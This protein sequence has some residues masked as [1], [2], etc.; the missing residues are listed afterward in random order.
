[1]SSLLARRRRL[2]VACVVAVFGFASIA[3]AATATHG[4][5]APTRR[6]HARAATTAS[7]ASSVPD[8]VLLGD[9]NVESTRGGGNGTSEAFGWIASVSGTATDITVYLESTDGA[10]VGLYA[11][12]G[13]SRPGLRLDR[14][15][16]YSNNAGWVRISLA[17]GAKVVSGQRYWIAI[18]ARNRT[19][20]IVYLDGGNHGP[21]FDYGGSG[22]SNPYSI[23]GHYAADPVSAYVDGIADSGGATLPP[24]NTGRPT[25]SGT[26]QQ[27]GVLTGSP[28][29]WTN[30]PTSFAYQWRRCDPS[31]AN[32]SELGG[33]TSSSYTMQASDV[34]STLQLQVT[35]SNSGGSA[36][37]TSLPTAVVAGPTGTGGSQTLHCFHSPGACGFPDPAYGNVGVPAGTTLTPSGPITVS[38][39][40]AIISGLDI[41]TDSAPGIRIQADN[42]TVKNTRITLAGGGCGT[43]STCGSALIRIDGQNDTIS[44]VELATASGITSEFAIH[45]ASGDAVAIDHVYSHGPDSLL[46]DWANHATVS[47]SYSRI[48]LRIANDHLENVYCSGGQTLTLNHNTLEDQ[49]GQVASAVFCNTSLNGSLGAPCT[50]HLTLTNNLLVGGGYALYEC[51]NASNSDSGSGASLV[52]TGNDLARCTS[53]PVIQNGDGGWSCNGSTVTAAGY[54][55]TLPGAS[56]DANGFFPW[57]GHYGVESYTYCGSANT[58]W[59]GNYWDDNGGAVA[60]SLHGT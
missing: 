14:A 45:N 26:A 39:P 58:T 38:T 33:A 23:R 44:H 32:C 8:P 48:S 46:E 31:G 59:S 19:A 25:V 28:G 22:L 35:A 4:R 13:S 17:G 6:A 21:G 16:V 30:S 11:D 10:R 37:G 57:G 29:T 1:M 40:G 12:D 51:G 27:G 42:V 34:G 9:Q 41:S 3:Q 43:Q 49:A 18:A 7:R 5:L 15:T 55:A 56:G 2:R 47:D 52:F 53:P 24:V 60:C 20:S 50:A 36:S 54:D